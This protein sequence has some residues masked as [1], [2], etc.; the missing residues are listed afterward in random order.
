MQEQNADEVL[1]R[2]FGMEV[3][4]KPE[5][6]DWRN[7]IDLKNKAT[8]YI[9]IGLVGKY[10]ELQDA[11]KSIDESLQQTAIYNGRRLNLV[12]IQSD[13]L[14]KENIGADKFAHVDG[15]V[16]ALVLGRV[17]WMVSW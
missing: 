9:N 15:V 5:M 17:V 8:E 16:I 10:V 7:F 11:Y 13:D 4:P 3:G 12:H 14:T 1:L 6:K 2:K